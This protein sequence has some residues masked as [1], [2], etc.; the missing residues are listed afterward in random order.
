M[1]D[2]DGAIFMPFV[3]T[4]KAVAFR[5]GQG[6]YIPAAAAAAIVKNT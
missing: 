1:V 5:R 4:G 6:F 3:S 2:R